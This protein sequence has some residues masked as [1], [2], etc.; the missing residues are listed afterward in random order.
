MLQNSPHCL[1]SS[2][3][4][5]YLSEDLHLNFARDDGA[6]EKK[7]KRLAPNKQKIRRRNDGFNNNRP[8]QMYAFLVSKGHLRMGLIAHW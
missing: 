7:K 4:P 1:V 2:F 6:R 5:A 8:V 3:Q